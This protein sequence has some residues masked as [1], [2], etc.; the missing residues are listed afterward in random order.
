[1][2][3]AE[4]EDCPNSFYYMTDDLAEYYNPAE[5]NTTALIYTMNSRA[6]RLNYPNVSFTNNRESFGDE[7]NLFVSAVE[8]EDMQR[9]KNINK[10]DECSGNAIDND[11]CFTKLNV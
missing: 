9:R 8:K 6:W 10:G 5:C 3:C 2:T 1:M 11:N 7:N 4:V